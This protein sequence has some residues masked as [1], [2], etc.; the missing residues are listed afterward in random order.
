MRS[1]AG[2]RERELRLRTAVSYIGGA[3]PT[4]ATSTSMSIPFLIVLELASVASN[5]GEGDTPATMARNKMIQD[6]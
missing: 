2:D 1:T 5:S 4:D 6:L 3:D